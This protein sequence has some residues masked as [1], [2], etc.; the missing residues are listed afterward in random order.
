M[1]KLSVYLVV[2]NEEKRLEKTLSAAVRVADELIVVD[3]GSTDGTVEIARR[4]KAKVYQN[5]WES[6]CAQKS[7]AEQKCR[8]DWVLLLDADEVMSPELI[9][10]INKLKEKPQYN[11]YKVKISDM[12]PRD[13]LPSRFARRF[14]PVRLY[15]RRYAFMP[16][17]KMNKDRVEVQKGEAIGQ[18]KAEIYHYSFLSISQALDKYNRHSD[19]LQK[20]LDKSGKK[21][22]PVRLWIEYPWQF[23]RYYFAHGYIFRGK[24]GLVYASL[25][26][27]FRFLKVAK[28]FERH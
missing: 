16:P 26:A 15:N 10:E 27:W 22:S 8:Y 4:Y 20:T 5:A 21:L 23:C 25:L 3:S 11:A 7:F 17:D 6:Y 2:Y 13:K 28:W 19:E 18:L 9:D 12:F 14:N 1:E 24:D